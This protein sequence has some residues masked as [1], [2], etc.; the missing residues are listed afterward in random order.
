MVEVRNEE[1]RLNASLLDAETLVTGNLL[2]RS[3]SFMARRSPARLDQSRMSLRKKAASGS[4]RGSGPIRRGTCASCESLSETAIVEHS[5]S[6][7][8]LQRKTSQLEKLFPLLPDC[9]S[10]WERLQGHW[11]R[12][13]R[14]LARSGPPLSLVVGECRLAR[15]FILR[16]VRGNVARERRIRGRR[17]RFE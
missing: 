1:N 4:L 13:C 9:R 15:G 11:R 7:K 17:Q 5:K 2:Q 14:L 8:L 3:H 6:M 12:L 16:S 10:E